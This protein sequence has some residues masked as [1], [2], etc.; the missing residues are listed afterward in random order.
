YQERYAPQREERPFPTQPP[1][2]AFVGNLKFD[3]TE[4]DIAFSLF[5]DCKV[6]D[7]HLAKDRETTMP[8][9]F[10]YV[11]FEDADSLRTA[12]SLNGATFIGRTVKVDLAETKQRDRGGGYGGGSGGRDRGYGGDRDRG[13]GG[14]GDRDR[15]GYGG[16]R[17]RGYGGDRDRGVYAGDRDRG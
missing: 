17:D 5:Q 1:Y 12:L 3:C 7:V 2:K 11:E 6:V 9:G 13:Y 14:G 10:G 15:G 4:E 16:D 8:R